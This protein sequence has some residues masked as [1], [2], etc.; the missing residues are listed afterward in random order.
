MDFTKLFQQSIDVLV[1]CYERPHLSELKRHRSHYE[2]KLYGQIE[3]K[4]FD[5]GINTEDWNR[6]Q[7]EN[8]EMLQLLRDIISEFQP[9]EIM[10]ALRK[11]EALNKAD[12]FLSKK[13]K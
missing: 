3:S 7:S 4:Y 12:Q 6:L 11:I 1:K 2:G 13:E 5:T 9:M 10:N 8:R